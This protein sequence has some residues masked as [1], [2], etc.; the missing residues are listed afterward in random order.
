MN[1]IMYEVNWHGNGE[2]FS[3]CTVT[4]IYIQRYGVLP[5]CSAPT[6]TAKDKSGRVF[7]GS[8]ED[9][10]ETEAEAWE[11]VKADIAESITQ[12]ERQVLEAQAQISAQRK[13]LAQL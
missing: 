8:L 4:P 5:G 10:Y 7:N 9:Y 2:V 1:K 3:H 6:I 13:F 12:Y 11:S